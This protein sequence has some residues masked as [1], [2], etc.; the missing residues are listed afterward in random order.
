MSCLH[1]KILFLTLAFTLAGIAFGVHA[2]SQTC[3]NEQN[4]TGLGGWGCHPGESSSLSCFKDASI[5]GGGQLCCRPAD[6]ASIHGGGWSCQDGSSCN[7][8]TEQFHCPSDNSYICCGPAQ[9]PSGQS[10]VNPTVSN[11]IDTSGNNPVSTTP[12]TP[13]VNPNTVCGTAILSGNLLA[14][15]NATNQMSIDLFTVLIYNVVM[16][17]LCIVG[18]LTL[19]MIVYGGIRMLISSG[20]PKN[21]DAGKQII[22]DAII[23]LVIVLTAY[24]LVHFVV[25]KML[26]AQTVFPNTQTNQT[27][28]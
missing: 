6:C 2:N 17:I 8:P 11:N 4:S 23:G 13:V 24:I 14:A 21:V 20:S 3:V 1:K 28:K 5:C 15:L 9:N 25:D 12:A 26:Q 7:G 27:N 19:I 10:N 16:L 22:V 18:A